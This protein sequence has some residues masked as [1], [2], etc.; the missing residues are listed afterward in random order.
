MLFSLSKDVA[1]LPTNSLHGKMFAFR[2]AK[3]C[4]IKPITIPD[5]AWFGA[6]RAFLIWGRICI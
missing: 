6:L 1:G 5:A 3:I 2:Q 4:A